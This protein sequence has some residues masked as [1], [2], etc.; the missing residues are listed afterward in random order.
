[1]NG[2]SDMQFSFMPKRKTVVS[3]RYLVALYTLGFIFF[4]FSSFFHLSVLEPVASN[5]PLF[6]K[7][8]LFL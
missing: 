1:M 3:W 2:D 5:K 4:P 6:Q 8:A 7:T